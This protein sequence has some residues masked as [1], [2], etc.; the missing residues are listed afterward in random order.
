MSGRRAI[1]ISYPIT[2][3]MLPCDIRS[4][5]PGCLG[6]DHIAAGLPSRIE[7]I[8]SGLTAISLPRVRTKS[9]N[10]GIGG[11]SLRGQYGKGIVR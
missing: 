9:A 8:H 1:S 10:A 4:W 7:P 3:I 6:G 2:H 11:V 5:R